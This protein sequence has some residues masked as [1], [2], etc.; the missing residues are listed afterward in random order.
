MT[1]RLTLSMSIEKH[2]KRSHMGISYTTTTSYQVNSFLFNIDAAQAI[3]CKIPPPP[4]PQ[5]QSVNGSF[6]ELLLIKFQICKVGAHGAAPCI[7]RLRKIWPILCWP[8]FEIWHLL[9]R[10]EGLE[11]S[12]QGFVNILLGGL[13]DTEIDCYQLWQPC[14]NQSKAHRILQPDFSLCHYFQI[15]HKHIAGVL[16]KVET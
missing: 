10:R 9:K 6:I 16:D 7:K 13:I 14:F 11:D 3:N 12:I 4:P 5:E 15:A 2:S 1:W 8:A